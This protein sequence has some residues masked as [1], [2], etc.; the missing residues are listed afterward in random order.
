MLKD[1][2]DRGYLWD[3]LQN[4]RMYVYDHESDTIYPVA[5]EP[6]E[7]GDPPEPPPSDWFHF[8]GRWGDKK[9]PLSDP[10]Q[11]KVG[12]EFH[13]G[14]GPTGPKDKNLGREF[15]CLNPGDCNMKN[16]PPNLAVP[17]V[18]SEDEWEEYRRIRYG[19]ELPE[20]DWSNFEDD[21]IPSGGL[22]LDF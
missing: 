21:T 12:G 14:N 9:Y 15:I 5:G 6:T 10:R 2:T 4:L 3:P 7:D 20:A 13:Y 16:W 17:Q 22:K 8:I 1:V 19:D 18:I 11:W